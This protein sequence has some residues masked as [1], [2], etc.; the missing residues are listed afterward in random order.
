MLSI[1]K[2]TY[3]LGDTVHIKGTLTNLTPNNISLTIS[4]ASTTIIHEKEEKAVWMNPEGYY[5]LF[6][7]PPPMEEVN[8]KPGETLSLGWTSADWNMTGLHKSI[9]SGR[10]RVVYDDSPVPEGQYYLSWRPMFTLSN[11][12]NHPYER[13]EDTTSFKITR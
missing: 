7:A 13:I 4:E 12:E 5:Q 10:N 1:D 11:V 8:L 6:L 9:Q 2:P 3:V